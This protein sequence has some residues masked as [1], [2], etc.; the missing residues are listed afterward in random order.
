MHL[1]KPNVT[2][3]V[4]FDSDCGGKQS[5]TPLSEQTDVQKAVLPA[6]LCHR[7]PNVIRVHPWL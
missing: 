3:V 2:G 1:D 4:T 6:A 7:T 5:A